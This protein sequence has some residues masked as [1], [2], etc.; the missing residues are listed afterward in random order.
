MKQPALAG[1]LVTF[2]DL[3]LNQIGIDATTFFSKIGMIK[4]EVEQNEAKAYAAVMLI[5]KEER[6]HFF[7]SSRASFRVPMQLLYLLS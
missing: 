3:E 1:L 5:Q 6:E 7:S 2:M 4:T